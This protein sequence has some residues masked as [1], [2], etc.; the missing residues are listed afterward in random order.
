MG[1][2]ATP[3]CGTPGRPFPACSICKQRRYCGSHCLKQI[4]K[5]ET[6]ELV[7]NEDG[8]MQFVDLKEGNLLCPP[9]VQRIK[10]TEFG[11]VDATSD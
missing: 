8:D 10:S 6:V 1:I 3:E 9:C 7:L 4:R 5:T 11:D 2:C